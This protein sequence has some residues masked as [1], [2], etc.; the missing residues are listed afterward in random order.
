M[1]ICESVDSNGMNVV[2]SVVLPGL[3]I[4]L[5]TG[6]SLLQPQTPTKLVEDITEIIKKEHETVNLSF[7]SEFTHLQQQQVQYSVFIC[8][9]VTL[10]F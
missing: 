3:H 4:C 8:Y 1:V 10:M 9:P 2:R 5:I 6:C 7:Q